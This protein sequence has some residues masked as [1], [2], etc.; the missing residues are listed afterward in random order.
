MQFVAGV[1]LT[2]ELCA[3][4]PQ[5]AAAVPENMDALCIKP[6]KHDRHVMARWHSEIP[7]CMNCTKSFEQTLK[8]CFLFV[9]PFS[10]TNYIAFFTGRYTFGAAYVS[11]NIVENNE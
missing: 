10:E 1:S 7:W 8:T 11:W 4:L 3:G 6:L 2:D 5:S 9:K